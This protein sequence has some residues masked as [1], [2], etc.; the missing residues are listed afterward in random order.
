MYAKNTKKIISSI[1]LPLTCQ[2]GEGGCFLDGVEFLKLGSKRNEANFVNIDAFVFSHLPSPVELKEKNVNRFIQFY[3]P[4]N[5][6]PNISGLSL[7][8]FDH[9]NKDKKIHD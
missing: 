5:I 8:V 7:W 3:S 1:S 2:N 9:C 6:I 4:G